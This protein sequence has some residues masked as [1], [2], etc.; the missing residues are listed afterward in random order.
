MTTTMMIGPSTTPTIEMM[1][2][3]VAMIIA[4]GAVIDGMI[5]GGGTVDSATKTPSTT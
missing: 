4:T 5:S 1:T 3:T 2:P